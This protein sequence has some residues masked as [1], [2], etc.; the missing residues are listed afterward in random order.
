MTSERKSESV[1]LRLAGG[2]YVLLPRREYDRLHGL[3]KVA[4]LPPLPSRDSDG[5]YPAVRYART[6]IART[7]VRERARTGLTQK[8]LARLAGVRVETL[9]R[10]ERGRNT[11]NTSTL[12]R[13]E[14]ALQRAAGKGTGSRK[15]STG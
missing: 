11:P 4:E 6:S 12:A 14:H 2:E 8:E 1:R 3:A 9:C 7:I 15:R 13:I 5:H 10:I